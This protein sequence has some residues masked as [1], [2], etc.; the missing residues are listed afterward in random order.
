MISFGI[1]S[2]QVDKIGQICMKAGNFNWYKNSHL[3]GIL[4]I[5]DGAVGITHAGYKANKF[6]SFINVKIAEKKLQFGS[7]KCQYMVEGKD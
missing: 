2:I 1:N 3:V 4:G 5:V 7:S 6:N